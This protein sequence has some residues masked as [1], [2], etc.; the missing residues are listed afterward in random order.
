MPRFILNNNQ[1]ANGDYEVHNT[2]KGCDWMP[3]PQNQIDLGWH[4]DCHKAVAF[5]KTKYPER[6]RTNGCIHCCPDC[7][8]S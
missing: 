5:A 4:A 2:T 6:Y 7:H 8:T 3:D 1:Q